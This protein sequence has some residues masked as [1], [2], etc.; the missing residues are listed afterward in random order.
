MNEEEFNELT[1]YQVELL[2]NVK[3]NTALTILENDFL[4][5]AEVPEVLEAVK[6][7]D[8]LV[9]VRYFKDILESVALNQG[10]KK[11]QLF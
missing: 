8:H 1:A 5:V 11:S 3:I 7:A 10:Y 4:A 2:G 9:N 6:E